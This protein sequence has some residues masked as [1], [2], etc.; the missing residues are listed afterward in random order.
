MGCPN[1]VQILLNLSFLALGSNTPW[2]CSPGSHERAQTPYNT[3]LKV[4]FGIVRKLIRVIEN[5]K[6]DVLGYCVLCD[7][8][9]TCYVMCLP[10]QKDNSMWVNGAFHSCLLRQEHECLSIYPSI[11][12]LCALM[13]RIYFWHIRR[14]RS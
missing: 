8:L 12:L 4:H 14:T 6:L 1:L 7:F 3:I 10:L 9:S 2:F 13:K 5:L 11:H